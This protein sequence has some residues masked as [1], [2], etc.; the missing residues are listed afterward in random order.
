MNVKVKNLN[1]LNKS[2]YMKQKIEFKGKTVNYLT[3]LDEKLQDFETIEEV[4]AELMK[5]ISC[6]QEILEIF[7]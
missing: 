7:L 1:D 6:F 5:Y 4:E 3:I 2:E